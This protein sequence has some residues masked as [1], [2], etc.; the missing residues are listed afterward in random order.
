MLSMLK[1]PSAIR[2]EA[3]EIAHTV[4]HGV[5]AAQSADLLEG[6]L[7]QRAAS[8]L[9]AVAAAA[10]GFVQRTDAGFI[11]RA[12][13]ANRLRWTLKDLGYHDEF[14]EALL[15]GVVVEMQR[16]ADAKSSMARVR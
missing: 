1:M 13:L 12:A 2:Q 15:A 3:Q 5:S 16:A 10:A 4:C 6:R 8:T 14:I 7:S 9:R 11:S